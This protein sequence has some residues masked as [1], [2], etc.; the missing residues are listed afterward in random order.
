MIC[1]CALS[2]TS[3]CKSCSRM[4]EYYYDGY[5]I[6]SMPYNKPYILKENKRISRLEEAVKRLN[7][8][9]DELLREEKSLKGEENE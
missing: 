2:G 3:A 1:W 6:I 8:R 4:K 7:E 9:I 5:E